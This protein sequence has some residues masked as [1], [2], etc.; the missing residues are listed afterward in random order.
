MRTILISGGLGALASSIIKEDKKKSNFILLDVIDN[1]PKELLGYSLKY[2]KSDITNGTKLEKTLRA[3]LDFKS[4]RIQGI[5][6]TPAWND[7]KNFNETNYENIE[8]TIK[9]KLIG[10]ANVIKSVLKIIDQGASILNVASVHAHST[11][12]GY[13]LYS[14][15]NGG[16][17]SLT[18]ALAVELRHKARVNVI[19]PGGFLTPMYKSTFPNWKEKL[20]NGQILSSDEIARLCLFLM[21]KESSAI[22]GAEIIADVGTSAMRASSS[23]W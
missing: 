16:V 9:V 4:T 12:E 21:S 14:A 2:I 11:Y 10:Y 22:N 18:K 5:I 23:N 20:E 17:I 19:S 13:A 15:A 8:K 6:N 1:V 7:F 3:E